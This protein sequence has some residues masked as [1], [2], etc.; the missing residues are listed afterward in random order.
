MTEIFSTAAINILFIIIWLII[1]ILAMYEKEDKTRQYLMFGF[2]L[3]FCALVVATSLT[4]V[5][6]VSCACDNETL[7]N[8]S[9]E[10]YYNVT[11]CDTVKGDIEYI[12]NILIGRVFSLI[13]LIEGII[14]FWFIVKNALD[15]YMR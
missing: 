4:E 7:Y 9:S 2:S 11:V 8:E 5:I 6:C 1:T 12:P 15:N 14:F 10:D 13:F 3:G